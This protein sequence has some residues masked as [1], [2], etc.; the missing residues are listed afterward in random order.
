M[1][2]TYLVSR[3][4]YLYLE[5]LVYP[6]VLC[7]VNMHWL[8]QWYDVEQTALSCWSLTK[9]CSLSQLNLAFS[10][11][12]SII[13]TNSRNRPGSLF[14]CPDAPLIIRYFML[15]KSNHIHWFVWFVVTYPNLKFNGGLAKTAQVSVRRYGWAFS[16]LFY[17]D[18]ITYPCPYTEA[19]LTNHY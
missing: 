10:P 9:F 2:N 11:F 15:W 1:E 18:M 4:K 17:L 19:S 7:N 5:L 6:C 14:L 13:I 8:R 12:I 16:F 3:F